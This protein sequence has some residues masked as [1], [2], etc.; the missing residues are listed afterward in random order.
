MAATQAE[1]GIISGSVSQRVFDVFLRTL[2]EPGKIESLPDEVVTV[3]LAPALWL[4][5]AIA[6]VDVR[7]CVEPDPLGELQGLIRDAT[8]AL[9]S[10]VEDAWVAALL[11]QDTAR[12]SFDR[13]PRGDALA[14]ENGA[15]C[16]VAVRSV[17][18]GAGRGVQAT[19]EGPGVPGRRTVTIDGVD[20]DLV[21]TTGR[22][23]GIFPAGVD[24]WFVSEQ[25]DVCA[26]SRSTHV[27]VLS[28][29]S[30]STDRPTTGER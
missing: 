27:E 4:P 25:G 7:A 11:D 10:P 28:N 15:R 19:V 30:R 17:F 3:G 26:V 9:A 29:R 8:G 23:S 5:L 12:S 24:T 13:L 2:A 16:A 14:P 1:M 6:A 21:A 22:A 18:S 20:P